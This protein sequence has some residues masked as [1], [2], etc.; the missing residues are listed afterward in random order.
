VEFWES[1]GSRVRVM[2]P[3]RHDHMLARTSHL[4][5]MTAALL[6]ATVG[7]DATRAELRDFCGSGFRDASRIADGSPEVWHDIARSNAAELAAELK[8]FRNRLNQAV[9]WL[10]SGDFDRIKA[11]LAEGR[12]ARRAL[13]GGS[14]EPPAEGEGP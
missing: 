7:R 3:A 8:A 13:L 9:D 11:L 5:H 1:L 2:D 12:A 14:A 6:A 4:P 10:E